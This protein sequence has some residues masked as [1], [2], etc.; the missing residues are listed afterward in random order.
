[1]Q[2]DSR[3]VIYDPAC[4]RVEGHLELAGHAGSPRLFFRRTADELWIDDH[5]TLL[6]LRPGAWSRMD[7]RLVSVD[8]QGSPGFIGDFWFPLDE[9]VCIVPRPFS[10]DVLLIDPSSFEPT[11]SVQTGGQPLEGVLLHDGRIIARDWHTRR[12]LFGHVDQGI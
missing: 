9:H 5:D 7:A 12:L 10:G 8:R 11:G 2:R 6:R 4:R 1:V 3:P